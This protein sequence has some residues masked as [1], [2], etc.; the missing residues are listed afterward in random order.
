MCILKLF[1]KFKLIF[2]YTH[3]QD[4]PRILI[5]HLLG[6]LAVVH[7]PVH[8]Q[9]PPH[10]E[11]VQGVSRRDGDIVEEAIAA[12]VIVHCVVPRGPVKWK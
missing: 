8:Y 9:Y 7:V 12:V 1:H 4:I 5:K 3:I 6:G 2:K 10:A 11:V